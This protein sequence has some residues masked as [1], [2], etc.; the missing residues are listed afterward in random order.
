MK[1]KKAFVII[2]LSVCV[3][4]NS[5]LIVN[6]ITL[7]HEISD[8]NLERNH[9]VKGNL[10]AD[11]SLH[12]INNMF[13]N[14]GI[15]LKDVYLTDVNSHFSMDIFNLLDSIPDGNVLLVCRINQGECG[16][17]I[18][19]ALERAALFAEKKD[20]TLYVWGNY[21]DDHLLKVLLSQH[22]LN[23]RIQCFNVLELPVPIEQQGNPYYFVLTK[24]GTMFDFYTPDKMLPGMTDRFFSLVGFKW[25]SNGYQ[26]Y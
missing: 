2:I 25:E 20:V 7:R 6:N 13:L 3:L 8:D 14:D 1:S 9:S 22:S 23:S 17:C 11:H 16:K 10:G 26:W 18:T 24:D 12:T 21:T 15:S 5:Y 19:Y 4:M